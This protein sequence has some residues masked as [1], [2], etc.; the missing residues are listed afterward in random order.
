MGSILFIFRL[1]PLLETDVF[2]RAATRRDFLALRDLIVAG[3]FSKTFLDKHPW[4]LNEA[5]IDAKSEEGRKLLDLLSV[6]QTRIGSTAAE[7]CYVCVS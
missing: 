6:Y 2:A 4:A 7:V 5:D 3:G 1:L